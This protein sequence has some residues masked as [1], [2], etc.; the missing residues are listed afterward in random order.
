MYSQGTN[1]EIFIPR[2]S[3]WGRQTGLAGSY[4]SR[5]GGWLSTLPSLR[6]G[7][8]T[9]QGQGPQGEGLGGDSKMLE[10][11]VSEAWSHPSNPQMEREC[12]RTQEI[13]KEPSSLY[14]DQHEDDQ[15]THM[16][17][18]RQRRPWL[19]IFTSPYIDQLSHSL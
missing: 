2:G 3:G 7:T 13:M 19:G 5:T 1:G 6:A 16:H 15:L 18:E 10:G 14:L 12:K 9:C 11:F 8:A 17:T 4:G